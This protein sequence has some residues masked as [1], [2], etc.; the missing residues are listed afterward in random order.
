M[1]GNGFR[2]GAPR[3]VRSGIR[4]DMSILAEQVIIGDGLIGLLIIILIILAILWFAR[5]V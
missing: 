3:T 2:R 1:S 4:R 5:R